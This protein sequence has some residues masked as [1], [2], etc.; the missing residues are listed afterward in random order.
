M[1]ELPEVETV[2]RGLSKLLLGRTIARAEIRATSLRA[3]PL[4]PNLGDRLT[5]RTVVNLKRR[6]K[7]ILADFHDGQQA[8]IHLG[9]TGA[10]YQRQP[11]QAP[12]K[13]DHILLAL[14]DGT[15]LAFNDPRRFGQFEVMDPTQLSNHPT[16]R[17]LGPE[18]LERHFTAKLLQ[19]RLRGKKTSIKLAL[20][21]QRVVAGLGNIYVCEALF[22]A[23]I[24]PSRPAGRLRDDEAV[25]LVAAIKRV[26]RAS[27]RAGG[28]T[29]R[30]YRHP[31]G[32]LGFFQNR[33]AV[34]GREGQTCR[35]C[36]CGKKSQVKRV[37]QG[38]RSSFF[39]PFRQK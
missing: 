21:D 25:R 31:D 3:R 8:L 17:T 23:G 32:E 13:H 37:T 22:Y 26:L 20:L 15:H 14:D 39:C 27:L 29:L 28:S 11:Q 6:A 7:Y 2:C 24:R 38:G 33:F 16:L 34:Y 12:D 18:P 5:G 10:F 35:G 19:E 9:M 30:D 1:P 4:P 36:N